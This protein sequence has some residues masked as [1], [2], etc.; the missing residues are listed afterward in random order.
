MVNRLPPYHGVRNAD[1]YLHGLLWKWVRDLDAYERDFFYYGKPTDVA[2]WY[3]EA[4]SVSTLAGAAWAKGWKCLQDY[5]TTGKA[6]GR[7]LPLRNRWVDLYAGKKSHSFLLEAKQ[8]WAPSFSERQIQIA[9]AAATEQLQS[10]RKK[11][12]EVKDRYAA[13]FLGCF[14]GGSPT[15]TSL[16][17]DAKEIVK[18]A[19]CFAKRE[20]EPLTVAWHFPGNATG[21]IGDDRCCYFGVV[22]LLQPVPW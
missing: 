13:V 4:T 2:Y 6:K 19:L 10:L 21:I 7:K 1:G 11:T 5:G 3:G 20:D 8:R 14:T 9:L 17:T 15:P 18:D 12:E 16:M 22:L